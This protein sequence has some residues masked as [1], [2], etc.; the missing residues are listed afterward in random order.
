M[1]LF[2]TTPFSDAEIGPLQVNSYAK[3]LAPFAEQF[4]SHAIRCGESAFRG[5][6]GVGRGAPLGP[7][8]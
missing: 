1:R 2:V 5:S 8:R 4:N 6:S 7:P 3:E